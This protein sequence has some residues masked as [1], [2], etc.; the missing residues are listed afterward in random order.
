MHSRALL[1]PVRGL[2][3]TLAENDLGKLQEA[4]PALLANM[5]RNVDQAMPIILASGRHPSPWR[6]PPPARPLALRPLT[7]MELRH[8]WTT[9]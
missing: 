2:P 5:N 7:I 1:D 4:V 3:S 6:N 9:L 8:G